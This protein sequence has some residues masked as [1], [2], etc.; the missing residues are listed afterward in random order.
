M[1]GVLKP[2]RF[3]VSILEDFLR[4][5]DCCIGEACVGVGEFYICRLIVVG[6]MVYVV[7]VEVSW[8]DVGC[9]VCFSR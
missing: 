4:Q 2:P 7:F 3:L 5:V 8:G 1:E 9:S 6:E